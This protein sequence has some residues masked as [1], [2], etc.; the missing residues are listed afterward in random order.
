VKP[1]LNLLLIFVLLCSCS[2][3]AKLR[4]ANRLIAQAEKEGLQ[5]HSDTLYTT[6]EVRIPQAVK[7][8]IFQPVAGDTVRINKDRLKIEYVQIPGGKV[9]IKGK[10]EADTIYKEVVQTVYKELVCPPK[11]KR[12]SLKQILITVSVGLI[13]LVAGGIIAK[14]IT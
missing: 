10:C 14:I 8:T 9:Y 4:R 12:W 3:A 7:D 13:C 1:Y 6:L 5:W 11:E 2:P